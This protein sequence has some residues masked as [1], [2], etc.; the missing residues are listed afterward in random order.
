LAPGAC[1]A[2]AGTPDVR[3]AFAPLVKQKSVGSAAAET[4][5]R[6]AA[7]GRPPETMEDK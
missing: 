5:E 6:R 7:M 1:R 3:G 2:A 4:V